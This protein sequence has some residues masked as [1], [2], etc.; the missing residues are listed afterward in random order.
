M[1]LHQVG[2][3]LGEI[4]GRKAMF[5]GKNHIDMV[6]MVAK[7]LGNPTDTELNWLPKETDAY[8]FLRKA[9]GAWKTLDFP[10]VS[11]FF[12]WVSAGFEAASGRDLR[13]RCARR[14]PE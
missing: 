6:C 14:A 13:L 11:R 4:L 5:P 12:P 1:H 8:R 7:V 2:C 3:I 9:S 10:H